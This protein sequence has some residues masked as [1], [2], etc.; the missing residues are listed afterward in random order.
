MRTPYLDSTLLYFTYSKGFKSGG[1]EMKGLEIAE[2]EPESV[3]NY[4]VGFKID[5]LDQRIR[6]NTACLLYGL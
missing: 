1:F 5:A 4:E 2:F 3:T 6:F